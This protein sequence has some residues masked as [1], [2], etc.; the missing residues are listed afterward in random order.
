[1]LQAIDGASS[2]ASISSPWSLPVD[3]VADLLEVE[4]ERGL[5]EPVAADRLG[6][7]G[8]NELP[9][10]VGPSLLRRF[11][12]QFS[13]PLVGLLL[14]AI[15]VSLVAW[16]SRGESDLP[17]EAIVIAAIVVANAVIGVW[18][19]GKAAKAVDALRKLTSEESSVVR[20]GVAGSIATSH[21]V[22]GDIVLLAEGDIVG[23]DGRLVEAASLDVDEASLTGESTVVEKS[24][25][26]LDG[27]IEVAD[28]VNMVMSGT[29]V[30]R[31]RGRAIVVATGLRTEVG[32]IAALLDEADDEPTPLQRQV[33]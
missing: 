29:S 5:T 31:G 25:G 30:A 24:T 10:R 4:T 22:P 16:W 19:E 32:R 20:N 8:L 7:I 14:G 27:H 13:D 33:A 28:R 18:Q 11:G 23:F 2:P 17:V 12:S 26:A 21:L 9:E 1:M 6:Q 15:V 3:A